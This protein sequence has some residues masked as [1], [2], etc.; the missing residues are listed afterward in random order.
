MRFLTR[1]FV[2]VLAV[3]LALALAPGLAS[4]T[5]AG[6][7][8]EFDVPT[9]SALPGGITPSFDGN[10][11]FTETAASKVARIAP[12]GTI[13]EYPLGAGR[14]P[15]DIVRGPDG[16]LWFTETTGNAI[17]RIDTDGNG[18]TEFALPTADS[19]PTGI[20]NGPDGNLWFTESAGNR[21]GRIT[22]AGVVTEFALPNANSAPTGIVAGPD[23][24]LWFTETT[25]N[26]IGR[27]TTAGIVSEVVLPNLG[28][29]PD[30]LTV[31]ADSR[32]WFT[33]STGDRIGR[34]EADFT[35]LVEFAVPAGTGP[36]GIATGCDGNLWY[37]A[38]TGNRVDRLTTDGTTITPFAL[39]N[40]GSE[41]A[42][43]TSGTDHDLW[44]TEN[45]G[46]RIARVGSGC[47][48]T[49]PQLV[50]PADIT[51]AAT[52]PAGAAVNYSVSAT[53]DSGSIADLA[54]DMPS[55][56][57][58][59]VGGTTVHCEAFDAAGNRGTGSFMVVVTPFVNPVNP[60]VQQL[61]AL[62]AKVRSLKLNGLV[63]NTLVATI[64]YTKDAVVRGRT[65]VACGLTTLFIDLTRAAAVLR[66]VPS[67]K[68][69]DL[70]N[71][72]KNIRSSIG[73]GGPVNPTT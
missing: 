30:Q 64:S 33:E 59:P 10:H 4:A 32:V 9:A 14:G 46:N 63:T 72:M 47:D 73:C 45:A 20:T 48:F 6:A 2:V 39:P 16:N 60:A 24:N 42:G 65:Q 50:L 12:S 56:S 62:S 58:F 28:S 41:P 71:D 34:L 27:M 36:A 18:F 13:T 31:G 35:G 17:G 8:A 61:D 29:G 53:D 44:V 49:A 40:A 7:V 67:A 1:L 37:A 23:D 15:S 5:N 55:G 68:A 21:I 70:V 19:T 66:L 26:R 3:P 54:C 22:T 11:W 38:R 52:G 51:A 57:T 25:G 43:I 69:T